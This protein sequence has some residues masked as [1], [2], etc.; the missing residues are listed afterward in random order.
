MTKRIDPTEPNRVP[1]VGPENARIMLIG[2]APGETEVKKGEPFTGLAGR[3]LN[4]MLA[5]AG[6]ARDACYVTNLVKYRPAANKFSNFYE[7][8]GGKKV[9]G[10]LLLEGLEEVRTEIARVRPNV[11]V[12]LGSYPLKLLADRD[13]ITNWRGSVLE[14]CYGKVIPTIH[15]A[16]VLRNWQYRPAVVSD[17]TRVAENA[18]SPEISISRRELVVSYNSEEALHELEKVKEAG[19]VAFDIETESDQVTC[20]SFSTDGKRSVCIPFWYG[21]S[22]SLHEAGVE[23]R[24]WSAIRDI[25]ESE[26]PGKIA[27]NGSYDIGFLKRVYGIDSRGYTFDTML[28]LHALYLELPKSLAFATSLYTDQPYYKFMRKT[29]SMDTHFRYNAMDSCVTYEIYEKLASELASDGLDVFYR[30]YIH[31]LVEPLLSMELRGVRFDTERRNKLR[32]EYRAAIKELGETLTRQVGHELN[33][34]S[35]PQMT[36][37]LYTELGYKKITKINKTTGSRSL[38]ADNDALAKCNKIR[39]NDAIQTVLRIRELSKIYSTY[40]EVKLDSDKRI[41]CTY[42]IT[43]TETGRLSSSTT[44]RGTGTNLQNI[45]PGEV[46]SLFIPDEG[47]VFINADLSQAEARVVAYLADERRLIEVFEQGGDIH[48]RNAANIFN[49]SESE[50]THEQRQ[51]AKRVVH[52]CVTEGHEVLTKENGWIDVKNYSGQKIAVW[53]SSGVIHFEVPKYHV[54]DNVA[55]LYNIHGTSISAT[56]TP[57]HVWPVVSSYA[58]KKY[59]SRIET[60]NMPSTGRIPLTGKLKG[61]KYTNYE[62]LR[63]VVATQADGHITKSKGIRFHLKKQSKIDR[64]ES[65]LNKLKYSYTK[66]RN[67]DETVSIYIEPKRCGNVLRYFVDD[68]KTFDLGRLM[69]LKTRYRKC[70]LEELPYWDGELS[71][72]PG[73]QTRY[74]TTN[75]KNAVIVQ[76]IAHITGQE[77]LLN[78]S[79]LPSGKTLCVV[80]FNKRRFARV[81]TMSINPIEQAPQKVYCFTTSTGYFLLGREDNHARRRISITGN[82]NYGMGERTFSAQ[83]GIPVPRAR[84]LLNRYFATYPRIKVWHMQIRSQLRVSRRLVTPFGRVRV[85]FSRWSEQLY[86]EGLAYIPQSTVADILNQGLLCLHNLLKED[87]SRALLLQVHDSVL[88]QCE[89]DD[90]ERTVDDI[91]NC[92]ER[93]VEINGRILTIPM[94]YS[95]GAN[96]NEAK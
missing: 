49:V 21:S 50:V 33:V 25:L 81:E 51:M 73:R 57:E 2:E 89:P 79:E 17:L 70:F 71:K 30:D 72:G 53:D 38:T 43:G 95:V 1:A 34:H 93:P 31:A 47:K 6:I 59:V 67:S 65:L 16:S 85:F 74:S 61:R 88:V 44:L 62:H 15:P 13:G 94:D 8:R 87:G 68:N 9:A 75:R 4:D 77:A 35:H 80:S 90:V 27:H 78:Y 58:G 60:K 36:K 26:R 40:L 22:G 28:G 24:I 64:L 69:Q 91:R 41:R 11:I 56:C 7:R 84:G 3:A 82:S 63:L 86:K 96:W 37:W 18:N 66:N 29:D 55:H 46:K 23:S 10:A 42:N 92:L 12:L 52:A 76:T 20:I 54:Y 48:R 5:E 14:T 45:P 32:A 39:A 19:A 83:T